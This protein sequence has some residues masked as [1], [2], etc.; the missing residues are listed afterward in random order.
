MPWLGWLWLVLMSELE[1]GW[2][3]LRGV[4]GDG[5]VRG[6][7]GGSYVRSAATNRKYELNDF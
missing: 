1:L 6:V 7:F 5:L 2:S 3:L 4:V